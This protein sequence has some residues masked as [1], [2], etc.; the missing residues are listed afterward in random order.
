[1]KTKIL[2]AAVGAL[3]IALV[4]LRVAGAAASQEQAEAVRPPL[5]PV[6]KVA[7]GEV[8]QRVSLTGT[9]RARNAVEVH[10]EAAGRVEEIQAKV[11]DVVRAGQVLATL[12]HDEIAWQDRAAQ[13]A[14]QVARAS[15]SGARLEHQRTKELHARDAA[16]LAQLEAAG[17]RLALAEAQLAQAEAAA[18]LARQQLQNARIRSPIAGVVTRRAVDVGAQVGPQAPAFTVED[19]R[20]LKVE[21][22]VD[23][24]DWARLAMGAYVEVAVDARPGEVFEGRVALR[25]QSLDPATRRAPVEIEVAS[26]SGKLVPGMFARALVD[27]GRAPGELVVPREAV[28]QGPD[29]AV[30]WRIANGRAEAVKAR[31]GASDNRS[32]VVLGGLAEGEVVAVAGQ[33][34]LSHGGPAEAAV[35]S[36]TASVAQPSLGA[37]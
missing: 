25:S 30:V 15:L 9:V 1:M 14:A 5:V 27:A 11:G 3:L 21:T 2:L 31:L 26:A 22:A 29:G 13:A 23:A 34:S 37:N 16:P 33:D 24:E 32:A 4:A 28:V 17:V 19:L 12:K 18:G 36:R 35:P 7:R 20:A 6:A 8:A 10:P